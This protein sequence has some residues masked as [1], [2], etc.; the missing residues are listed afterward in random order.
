MAMPIQ[1]PCHL[2]VT[3]YVR[4]EIVDSTPMGSPRPFARGRLEMP[5]N[6]IAEGHI[7]QTQQ[8]ETTINRPIG[9]AEQFVAF[10]RESPS[11]YGRGELARSEKGHKRAATKI[12]SPHGAEHLGDNRIQRR[13]FKR[14]DEPPPK[15][16]LT[17]LPLLESEQPLTVF[18]QG[19]PSPPAH[20]RQLHVGEFS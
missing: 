14:W 12:R 4:I 5:I 3:G 8:I 20:F 1:F 17:H 7:E 13:A 11:K 2:R 10:L 15:G 16:P 18:Q 19:L 6:R 9:S